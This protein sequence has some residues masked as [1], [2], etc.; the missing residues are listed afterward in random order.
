MSNWSKEV[1]IKKLEYRIHLLNQRDPV[2]NSKIVAALT[3]E[4]RRLRD[5]D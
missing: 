5:E 1:R 3:R 2:A 4:L